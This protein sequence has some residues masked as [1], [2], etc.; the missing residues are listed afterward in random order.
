MSNPQQAGPT[1]GEPPKCR[2]IWNGK[3]WAPDP[4]Y[5]HD[6]PPGQQCQLP[7]FEGGY[8]GQEAETQ[9]VPI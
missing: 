1:P 2:W 9:C 3:T 5:P 4:K 6:C 8:I 7:A